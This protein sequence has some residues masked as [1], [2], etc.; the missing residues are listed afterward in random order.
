MLYLIVL[1]EIYGCIY[2]ALLWYKL[3]STTLK[4][5][6]FERNPFDRYMAN[7]TFEGTKFTIAWYVDDNK[8][9]HKNPEVI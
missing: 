9:S 4:G 5:L 8:L 2:S 1:M 6:G 7:K 3:F